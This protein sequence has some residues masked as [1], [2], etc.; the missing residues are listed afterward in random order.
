MAGLGRQAL[1]K[2]DL[3]A[4][5]GALLAPEILL[6]GVAMV[7]FWATIVQ[8]DRLLPEDNDP[9]HKDMVIYSPLI[10]KEAADAEPARLLA[11]GKSDEALTKAGNLAS[12]KPHDV[13]ANLAAGNVFIKA[14]AKDE[15][16]KLLKRSVA[17]APRSRFVRLNLADK[18]AED[19]RYDDAIT[20]YKLISTAYPHWARPHQALADI[21]SEMDQQESAA[22]EYEKALET[23]PNNGAM[24]KARGLALARGGNGRAGLDEFV[25]GETTEISSGPPPDVKRLIELWGSLD[26]AT[27]ELRKELTNRPDEP[28]LKLAL[29]RALMYTGQVQEAK[30]LLIEARKRAPQNASIHRNLALVMQK[31]GDTNLALSEFMMSINLERNAKQGTTN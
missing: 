6:S 3:T 1:I 12:A 19:K 28:E 5:T 9:G 14:G 2:L 15:G 21:Y 27:F 7:A 18:L 20:Q 29:A 24:K 13:K 4:V 17:L 10:L 23:E 8:P 26:R 31:M 11:A 22:Q 30:Q 16:F 25:R